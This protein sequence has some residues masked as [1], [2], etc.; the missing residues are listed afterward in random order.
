VQPDDHQTN[1]LA[2]PIRA[3][4]LYKKLAPLLLDWRLLKAKAE[5]GLVADLA[6]DFTLAVRS[7]SQPLGK[8]ALIDLSGPRSHTFP[9]LWPPVQS[10]MSLEARQMSQKQRD[11]WCR[12]IEAVLDR[13]DFEQCFSTRSAGLRPS[14]SP[15]DG[16]TRLFSAEGELRRLAARL[17]RRVVDNPEPVS[18]TCA[19]G[20]VAL[21]HDGELQLLFR[22]ELRAA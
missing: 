18:Y 5:A 7:V 3:T 11:D 8:M 1:G 19:A 4:P 20:M 10:I 2:K 22:A 17:L 14:R 15:A 21:K 12:Q 9:F 13:F 16:D 6:G